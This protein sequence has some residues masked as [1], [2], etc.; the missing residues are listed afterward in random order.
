MWVAVV[1]E[2]A[3]RFEPRDDERRGPCTRSSK[4]ATDSSSS[5]NGEHRW[6]ILLGGEKGAP[7]SL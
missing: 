3:V 4:T 6:L 1:I 2:D 7:A 5:G